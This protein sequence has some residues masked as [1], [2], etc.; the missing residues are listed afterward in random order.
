MEK[1]T[2]QLIIEQLKLIIEAKNKEIK[3]LKAKLL[4]NDLFNL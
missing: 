1:T 4:L 2:D 3:N